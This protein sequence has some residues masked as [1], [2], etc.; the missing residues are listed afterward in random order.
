MQFLPLPQP[1]LVLD[2]DWVDLGGGY[3]PRYFTHERQSPAWEIT[4]NWTVTESHKSDV[5]RTTPLSHIAM[6]ST[7]IIHINI[8]ELWCSLLYEMHSC[9]LQWSSWRSDLS[10]S[11]QFVRQ[12]VTKVH[13]TCRWWSQSVASCKEVCHFHSASGKVSHVMRLY[14]S[15][16]AIVKDLSPSWVLCNIHYS[17]APQTQIWPKFGLAVC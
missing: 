13:S 16:L 17:N 4:V 10:W 14:D 2:L 5:L 7:V 3:I 8:M 12:P 6:W 11:V 15:G 1:K 9:C